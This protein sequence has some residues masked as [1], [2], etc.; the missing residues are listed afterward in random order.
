[1]MVYYAEAERKALR[2]IVQVPTD[3][4]LV[5]EGLTGSY[6]HLD[7]LSNY[8]A[9]WHWAVHYALMMAS[10]EAIIGHSA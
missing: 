4:G 8:P 1:M 9:L 3:I 2:Y 7:V 6:F 10:D 5:R